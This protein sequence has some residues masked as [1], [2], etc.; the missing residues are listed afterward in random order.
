LKC[1]LDFLKYNGAYW[2]CL[3]GMVVKSHWRTDPLEFAN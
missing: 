3:N 2:I 1:Q